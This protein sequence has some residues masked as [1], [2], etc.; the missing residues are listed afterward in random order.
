M[1][2]L[3]VAL[4]ARAWIEITWNKKKERLFTVAL[5][6][7]A[8]IEMNMLIIYIINTHVALFARAWIEIMSLEKATDLTV[9][10]P[11]CEGV[12]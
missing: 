4:F 2:I 11:L 5:F 10:R 6:A 9:S 1:A 12:D 8:W 3:L 7:R